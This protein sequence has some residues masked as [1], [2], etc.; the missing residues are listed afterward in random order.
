MSGKKISELPILTQPL[1]SG[2]TTVVQSGVTYQTTLNDLRKLYGESTFVK[3]RTDDFTVNTIKSRQT[4][5]NPSNLT[6]TVNTIFI[7][8]QNADYYILGDLINQGSIVVN[9]NLK[10]GGVIY[11]TGDITGTGIIE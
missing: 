7:V 4:I 11:N 6:V 8:E 3:N 1:L 5:F 9:G 10:V 2:V